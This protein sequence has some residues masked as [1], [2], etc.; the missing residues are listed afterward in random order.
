MLATCL[1]KELR[2]LY[3]D[4]QVLVH[5]LLLPLF[6]YPLLLFGVSQMKLLIEGFRETEVLRVAIVGPDERSELSH[7]LARDG[8]LALEHSLVPQEKR[9]AKGGLELV[10]AEADGALRLAWDSRREASRRARDLV[11]PVLDAWQRERERG[12]ARAAGI[13]PER[14]RDP[15]L[16]TVDLADHEL[17]GERVLALLLPLV[18]LVMTTFGATWPALELTA[19]ERVHGAAETTALL[20]VRR[21]TIALAKLLAVTLCTF[22][23][24]LVNLLAVALTAGPL[25]A[26][27]GSAV[28]LPS[29]FFSAMPL[30][31][32]FGLLL[33]VTFASLFLLA[34]SHA[35]DHREAQA[36]ATPLQIV[37]LAPGLACLVS[38]D[39]APLMTALIPVYNAGQG[40][41]MALLGTGTMQYYLLA[42]A[43]M[44]LFTMCCFRLATRRLCTTRSL[45][46]FEDPDVREGVA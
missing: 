18:L 37:A 17:T 42:L 5:S 24:L 34:G 27:L 4:R 13:A 30:L 3:R 14:M 39:E 46:G 41:R 21:R 11:L 23:A 1:L 16:E 2:T 8:H 10:V 36:F 45:L 19:G 7:R 32:G 22:Q 43:S 35:K 26:S 28:G 31:L 38:A 25:L 44:A 29:A 20:P 15:A 9:L 12:L 40:F 33:S 6:L